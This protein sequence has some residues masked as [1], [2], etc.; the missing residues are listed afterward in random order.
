MVMFLEAQGYEVKKNIIFQDNQ[1]TIRMANTG[2]CSF[3]VNSSHINIH[4]FIM[5]D[6]VDKGEIEVQYCPTNFIIAGYFTKPLQG[7]I[8]NFFR[9]LIMIYVHI[10]DILQPIE[11]SSNDLADKQKDVTVNSITNN[12]K[13]SYADVCKYLKK[14]DVK[15]G[16]RKDTLTQNMHKQSD[17]LPISKQKVVK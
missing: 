8:F 5:K 1:S 10:N 3:T 4:H 13:I 14:K 12:G 6:R 2:R 11:F 7:K 9:D 17:S 15:E 16:E